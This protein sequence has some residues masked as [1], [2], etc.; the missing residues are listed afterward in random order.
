MKVLSGPL[1]AGGVVGQGL[2]VSGLGGGGGQKLNV[3]PAVFGTASAGRAFEV[4]SKQ[5]TALEQI[6]NNTKET[7]ENTKP[8]KNLPGEAGVVAR[9]GAGAVLR[10]GS[11]IPM[12]RQGSV[13]WAGDWSINWQGIWESM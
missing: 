8:N 9:L 2:N 12:A 10:D 6:N 7:A 13:S 1:D 11:G 3:A 4:R 5:Q